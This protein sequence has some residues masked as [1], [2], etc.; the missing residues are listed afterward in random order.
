MPVLKQSFAVD[1]PRDQVWKTFQDL[2]LV[3][4]CI[5]GASLDAPPQGGV[6][7][8]RMTVKLGPVKADFGGEAEVEYDADSYTGTIIGKGIDKSHSSRAK[9]EVVFRL[10]ESDHG[11]SVVHV[12]VDYTLSGSLAQFARGGIVDAVADHITKSFAANL[13]REFN[14]SAGAN[15]VSETSEMQRTEKRAPKTADKNRELNLFSL[16]MAILRSKFSGLGKR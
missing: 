8:G 14:A 5:P 13:E 15:D 6:A 2:P 11:D 1:H 3:V 16:I 12:D 10:E 9:G 4:Q 7:K